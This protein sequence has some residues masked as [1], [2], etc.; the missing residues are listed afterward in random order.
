L[1][2]WIIREMPALQTDYLYP[3]T[4]FVVLVIAAFAIFVVWPLV[5]ALGSGRYLWA[6][7]IFFL[8]PLG[9]ILWLA[10]GRR[11]H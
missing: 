6:I 9:G 2:S 3:S 5:E 1:A 10:V 4:T 11:R 8:W 7:A